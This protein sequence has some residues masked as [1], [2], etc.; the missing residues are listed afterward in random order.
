MSEKR[1]PKIT[2][3]LKYEAS[4]GKMVRQRIELYESSLWVE[5]HRYRSIVKF[6]MRINGKWWQ[7][8]N[9]KYFYKTEIRD[10]LWKNIPFY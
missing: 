3:L 8:V 1:K 2:M 7:D 9:K 4:N 6:R 5:Y 10:L